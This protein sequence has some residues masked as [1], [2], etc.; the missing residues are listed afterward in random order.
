MRKFV[1]CPTFAESHLI[2]LHLDN[3][4]S[5]LSPD[6]IVYNEG[7]FPQGP[8]NKGHIDDAFI[9]KWGIEFENKVI[10]FDWKDT[11]ATLRHCNGHSNRKSSDPLKYP[12]QWRWHTMEYDNLSADECFIKAMSYST[13]DNPGNWDISYG[14]IIFLLEP[15]AFIHE[16]DVEFINN[17]L[18]DL[19]PGEGISCKWVDFLETQYYTEAINLVQPKYRR[20]A[21]RFDNMENYKSAINGFTSQNYTKLKKADEFFIRHYAWFRPD[22]WKQLRYDLIHRSDPQYWKDFDEGLKNIRQH[23]ENLWI[24][25]QQPEWKRI[26]IRP[27]RSDEGRYAKFIDIEHPEAIKKHPNFVK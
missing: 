20:F 27:S 6:V 13:T 25:E 14:D 7:L 1:I 21:Y 4:I 17:L 12:H 23:S 9:A 26:V 11:L 8:E 3:M 19:Q 18:N 16:G 2:G 10:G 24:S 15:D 5:T 22:P